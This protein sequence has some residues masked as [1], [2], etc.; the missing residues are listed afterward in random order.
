MTSDDESDSLSALLITHSF[1]SCLTDHP[2]VLRF[3]VWMEANGRYV[4]PGSFAED[5][6][7]DKHISE[8]SS[9]FDEL[10]YLILMLLFRTFRLREYTS[11]G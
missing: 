10:F 2:P 1:H 6:I 9:D 7:H 8:L 3:V 5:E 4:S 11:D